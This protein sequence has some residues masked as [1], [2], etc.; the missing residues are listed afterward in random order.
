MTDLLALD[1]VHAYY[2]TFHALR[3]N[4][5]TV[6]EGEIVSLRGGAL[7]RC[8][9]AA[10]RHAPSTRVAATSIVA[11][12]PARFASAVC[13]ASSLDGDARISAT[14]SSLDSTRTRLPRSRCTMTSMPPRRSQRA[15]ASSTETG[16]TS[17]SAAAVAVAFPVS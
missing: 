11:V 15:S 13:D 17:T 6:G 1:D 9:V 12:T 10:M 3:G 4:T 14:V 5:L 16:E 7:A 2:G 8:S